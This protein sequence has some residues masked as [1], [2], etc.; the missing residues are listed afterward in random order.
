MNFRWKRKKIK[1]AALS[2]FDLIIP[3]ETS[4]WW[5][6]CWRQNWIVTL[7]LTTRNWKIKRWPLDTHLLFLLAVCDVFSYI[8]CKTHQLVCHITSIVFRNSGTGHAVQ[9][10]NIPNSVCSIQRKRKDKIFFL[11]SSFFFLL[12][13]FFPFFMK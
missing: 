7:Q 12:S 11:L 2:S 9:R 6:N 8:G 5:A 4:R 1:R 10:G 13:S 3:L